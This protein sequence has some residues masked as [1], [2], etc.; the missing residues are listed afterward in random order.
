MGFLLLPPNFDEHLVAYKDH[1]PTF[2]PDAGNSLDPTS[3]A[4][5]NSIVR[6]GQIV[7]GSRRTIRKRDIVLTT[8]WI[9]PP[10]ADSL[11]A[12]ASASRRFGEFAGLPVRL[13]LPLPRSDLLWSGSVR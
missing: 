12:A 9:V 8:K 2:H 11:A 4:L 7:V 13:E 10:D 5:A 6:N 3:A 1:G